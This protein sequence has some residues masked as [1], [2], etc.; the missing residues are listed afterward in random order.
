MASTNLVDVATD[1]TGRT[2][3]GLLHDWMVE[4]GETEIE[5]ADYLAV[6]QTQVGRWRR[7]QTVPRSPNLEALGELLG[8]SADELEEVRVESERVRAEAIERKRV[9]PS[10]AEELAET[11]EELRR[12]N[13][14]IRRLERRLTD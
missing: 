10:T 13:A 2:I 3:A 9:A 4:N 5:V 1:T 6:D 7:G 12:A 11:K 8:V 14:K